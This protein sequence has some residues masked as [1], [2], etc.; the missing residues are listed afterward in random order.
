MG[1]ER[2]IFE[3][4]AFDG[5]RVIG[6]GVRT[7]TMKVVDGSATLCLCWLEGLRGQATYTLS[8]R[9]LAERG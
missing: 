2:Q 6:I 3:C 7:T 9:A 1:A 5:G 4:V 8:S